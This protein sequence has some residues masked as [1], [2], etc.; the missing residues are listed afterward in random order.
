MWEDNRN[1]W[2]VLCKYKWFHI[3]ESLSLFFRDK[4][5]LSETDAVTPCPVV[6]GS[7]IVRCDKCGK[8][9]SYKASEVL[10]FELNDLP[11]SF[12]PHPLFREG[13]TQ[14]VVTE[15][16]PARISASKHRLP[17]VRRSAL[18]RIQSRVVPYLRVRHKE[19]PP[20]HWR[21][22]PQGK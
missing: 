20:P 3:R 14:P 22:P 10:R 21:R 17:P 8:E 18:E 7:L 15:Q 2:V 9:A 5:A 6:K 11:E 4:I 1:F 19:S 12:G 16:S 13:G